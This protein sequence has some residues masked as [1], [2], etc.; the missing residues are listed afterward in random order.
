MA[1]GMNAAQ[2]GCDQGTACVV[3]SA[4]LRC[5]RGLNAMTGRNCGGPE[6]ASI[7]QSTSF[8]GLWPLSGRASWEGVCG[9]GSWRLCLCPSHIFYSSCLC[10]ACLLQ[11]AH[12]R[13][14]VSI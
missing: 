6:H 13:D 1:C 2:K 11:P 8:E 7:M 10:I 5:E 12:E 4:F 3:Q 9:R 14:S